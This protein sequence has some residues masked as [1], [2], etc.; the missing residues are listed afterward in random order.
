MPTID[1]VIARAAQSAPQQIAV[2]EWQGRHITYAELDAA[3]SSFA[4]W[5]RQQGVQAGEAIAIH[6]PNSIAFLVAQ[7][8]SFRAGAVATY[9]S[10]RLM[11]N[12][13]RRQFSISKARMVVTTPEKAAEFR[14]DPAFASTVLVVDGPADG[15]V[16]SLADVIDSGLRPDFDTDGMEDSDAII[17]FTSGSTGDPKGLIVTHRAWLLRAICM[18]TEEMRIRPGTTTLLLGQLSHQAG[19][20]VLPTFLQNGTLLVVEKFSLDTVADILSTQAVSC[21][22]VVPTMFTLMLNHERARTALAESGL[23]TVIYGGSPIR[24]SVL[25]EVMAVLPHTEFLQSYGSHEAGSITVLDNAAH[26]DP[27]LRH[28]AGRPFLAVQLRLSTPNADGVGEIEV[29]SPWLPN[30]RLTPQGRE[31][32]TEAWSRTGDL[33]ELID[34]HVYLRDRMNDVIISGGFNVYPVEVEKVI[35][36]HPQ[37]L[38]AAVASAPDD[39]WGERVI[40][41]VVPRQPGAFNEAGM[42]EH[43]KAQLA[44]YKVPKEFHLIPEMPLNVNGKPDRRSLAQ[45]LWAGRER[46][47]N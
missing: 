42:R 11:P 22:Q 2:R 33:G 6:L 44:G 3:V 39:Q 29:K 34:G 41:F 28:S 38:D 4:A 46:R 36:A 12:E 26:R 15:A 35:G 24:Q 30:A 23:Q 20:F 1:S 31:P 18:Q 25:E 10:Y 16:H 40:A 43:C 7:F 37:V 5:A 27:R 14:R 17:R 8:G 13:A 32:I 45:P 21:A 47:I 19:L 9:V